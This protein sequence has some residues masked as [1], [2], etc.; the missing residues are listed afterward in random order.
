MTD[1]FVEYNRNMTDKFGFRWW[2]TKMTIKI[3]HDKR[4]K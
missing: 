2:Q 1:K 3:S 4:T